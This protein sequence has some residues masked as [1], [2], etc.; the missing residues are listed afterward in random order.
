VPATVGFKPSNLEKWVYYS[1]PVLLPLVRCVKR[2]FCYFLLVP[3]LGGFEP[4]NLGIMRALLYLYANTPWLMPIIIFSTIFYRCQ[5]QLDS[6]PQTWEHEFI[7]PPL[8]YWRLSDATKYFFAI[9]FLCQCWGDSNPQTSD[10]E[11]IALQLCCYRLLDTKKDYFIVF[12]WC[13]CWVGS[14]SQTWDHKWISLPLSY[15]HNLF[16]K[17]CPS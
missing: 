2:F 9:F 14:N 11:S 1:T 3:V 6:N 7:I 17:N 5:Q 8:F 12:S 13:Q 15:S 4:F 10:C 16:V